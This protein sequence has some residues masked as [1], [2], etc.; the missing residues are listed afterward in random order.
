ME[1]NEAGDAGRK[2]K[3]VPPGWVAYPGIRFRMGSREMI[4]T[5]IDPV[6]YVGTVGDREAWDPLEGSGT[7]RKEDKAHRDGIARYIEENEDYVL[8]SILVYYSPN[9]TVFVPDDDE[10]PISTGTLFVRP[11]AKAKVGDGGHRTSAFG[12]VI[13]AHLHGDE[14]LDRLMSN[15]QPINVVIDDD[16]ARRAQ[17]FTDLQNNAKPLNASI[18]QSMDRRQSINKMLLEDVLKGGK[19]PAFEGGKRIEFLSDSPGKLSPKILGFKSLRYATGTLLIGTGTRSARAW[20]EAVGVSIDVAGYDVTLQKV[21]DFWNGF[22]ALPDVAAALPVTRGVTVLRETT[23]LTSANVIYALAAA[24]HDVTTETGVSITQ[25]M[26]AAAGIDFARAS[27][28][29]HGTLVDPA[30]TDDDGNWVKEKALTGRDA[31]EGAA[32][33]LAS[34]IRRA[35]TG[36]VPAA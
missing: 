18:A 31:W 27:T 23:W 15:G 13:Q 3:R 32:S 9:D 16:Q 21:V 33:M 22:G 12:D 5:V 8:N 29:F 6:T 24:V 11:G 4:S 2:R 7:N 1:I 20:D 19:V 35:L 14:V 34:Q 28:T 25:A 30:Y 10:A 26:K 36:A 17:D